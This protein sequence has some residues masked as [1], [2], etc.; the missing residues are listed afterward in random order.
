MLALQNSTISLDILP[1]NPV[2]IL[3]DKEGY[4]I[5]YVVRLAEAS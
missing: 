3:A 1:C 5:R 4:H 2:G